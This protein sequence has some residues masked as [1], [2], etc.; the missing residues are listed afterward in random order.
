M[1]DIF[2]WNDWKINKGLWLKG[3]SMTFS[4]VF[5]GLMESYSPSIAL[6]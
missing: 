5:T 6:Q 3:Y 4:S 1:F 2:L